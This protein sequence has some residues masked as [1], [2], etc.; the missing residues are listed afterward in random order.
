MKCRFAAEN[1]FA[2]PLREGSDGTFPAALRLR[3]V[4]LNRYEQDLLRRK[5]SSGGLPR[6]DCSA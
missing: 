1:H 4:Y 3:F 6:I 5:L 2:E